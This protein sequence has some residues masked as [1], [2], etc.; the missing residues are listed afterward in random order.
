MQLTDSQ[1]LVDLGACTFAFTGV[2]ANPATDSGERVLLLEKLQRFFVPAIVDQGN[3]TLNA[4]MGRTG[5]LTGGSSLFVYAKASGNSLRILF[6]D[7]FSKIEFFVVLIR[8]GDRADLFALATARA[9]CQ[10]YIPRC[11][12]NICGKVSR[13]TFDAQKLGVR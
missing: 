1:G 5:C 8:A 3:K 7:C 10:I 9:L 2:V 13:L 4:D 12:V 11:L 6:E